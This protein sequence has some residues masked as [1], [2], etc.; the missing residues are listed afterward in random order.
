MKLIKVLTPEETQTFVDTI[1][2]NFDQ[3]FS[4]LGIY[5]DFDNIIYNLGVQINNNTPESISQWATQNIPGMVASVD[6]DGSMIFEWEVVMPSSGVYN[7]NA[8]LYN[9]DLSVLGI[10][11]WQ[12]A[13]PYGKKGINTPYEI[14]DYDDGDMWVIKIDGIFHK[15][16]KNESGILEIYTDYGFQQSADKF[17][18]FIN[19]SDPTFRK[20]LNI[21]LSEDTEPLKFD[22]YKCQFTDIKDW[23]TD[24]VETE[25]SKFEYEEDT[26]LTENDEPKFYLTNLDSTDDPK[27]F[28][29]FKLGQNVVN[30]PTSSEYTANHELFRL[31]ENDLNDLWRKNPVRVKWGYQNS[32]SDQDYPYLLNNSILADDFNKTVNPFNRYVSRSDK[33]LDYFYTINSD[34]AKYIHHS[35]HVQPYVTSDLDPSTGLFLNYK[36]DLLRYVQSDL[37]YFTHFFGQLNS[38]SNGKILKNTNKWSYFNKSGDLST[39]DTLFR[40]IKFKIYEVDKIISEEGKINNINLRN[41]DKFEGYK[42]SILLSENEGRV[43][44]DPVDLNKGITQSFKNTLNWSIIDQF[45]MD[46][47]YRRNDLVL[48]NNIL[49]RLTNQNGLT[50]TDPRKSPPYDPAN[51]DQVYKRQPT[52]NYPV[53]ETIF[54]DTEKITRWPHWGENPNDIERMSGTFA[55]FPFFHPFIYQDDEFHF[56]NMDL[57]KRLSFWVPIPI[58][59]PIP[60]GFGQQKP[61]KPGSGV[62]YKNRV[63]L[64]FMTGEGDTRVNS[65]IPGSNDAVVITENMLGQ[66]SKSYKLSWVERLRKNIDLRWLQVP[67]WDSSVDYNGRSAIRSD[68]AF[69]LVVYNDV[70]YGLTGPNTVTVPR[71]S[72]P[73]DKNDKWV[74]VYSMLPEKDFSYSEGIIGNEV[75]KMHNRFYLYLRDRSLDNQQFDVDILDGTLDNG[76][77]VYINKKHKNILINI[78]VNDN[79]Y[80]DSRREVTT[81]NFLDYNV[82]SNG[83]RIKNVNRDDIYNDLFEKLS[84]NNFINALSD[85]STKYD[86]INAVKYVIIEETGELKIYDFENLKSAEN[87]PLILTCEGPDEFFVKK[88]SL[89]KES[90]NVDSNLLKPKFKL[91][92]GYIKSKVELNYVGDVPIANIITEESVD[93]PL[94]PNFSSLKNEIFVRMYRHSGFYSPIFKNIELFKAFDLDKNL[95]NFKFDTRL[96]NFG[97]TGERIISKVNRNNNVLKL[98]N[99]TSLKSIYPMVDEFG[100]HIVKTFIFKSTW[101]FGH[102]YEVSVPVL[103]KKISNEILQRQKITR[104]SGNSLI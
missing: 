77:C 58:N 68:R 66:I 97:L 20:S 73:P 70:L 87:L 18:Y 53:I 2:E 12:S 82:E 10:P 98:N 71:N 51:W 11:L 28:D 45:K 96:T 91:N 29:D 61:Y 25:F 26:F 6:I 62:I 40:G 72:A 34:N 50:V 59:D 90:T 69:S 17:D 47:F 1:N 88:D 19:E 4:Q 3:S 9:P 30:I 55:A 67:L 37:D 92:D 93:K 85:L 41:T 76:I 83:S 104:F 60:T 46:K 56:S 22:I 86:F 38:F 74:R 52:P 100:Y 81:N 27:S 57:N 54:L 14:Q 75:I 15:L 103:A 31:I 102:H 65:S 33:N 32:I 95:G 39:N 35:L 79:T 94:V 16:I 64:S 24:I 21:P 8:G 48:W 84:A 89:R 63:W 101:D 5:N 99:V 13:P 78:Y 80:S 23:D 36:F 43:I 7:M 42:F 49:Y 44:M